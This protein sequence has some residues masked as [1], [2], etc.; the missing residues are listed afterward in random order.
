MLV[1]VREFPDVPVENTVI[2]R[3]NWYG[4]GMHG[5]RLGGTV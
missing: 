1:N 5:F 3:G 2:T 4:A